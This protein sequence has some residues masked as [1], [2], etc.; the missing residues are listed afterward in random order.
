[1]LPPPSRPTLDTSVPRKIAVHCSWPSSR[2]RCVMNEP[3]HAVF[4]APK[5]TTPSHV[6]ATIT[7][8]CA[9]TAIAVARSSP[10][11]PI[12]TDHRASP[13]TWL[14]RL[15]CFEHAASPSSRAHLMAAPPRR[16]CDAR[17]PDTARG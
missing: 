10:V 4:V 3:L 16:A 2:A 5:L 1:M 12:E 8:P 7:L 11:L 13:N 9:S 6:P 14:P 15:S 17:S